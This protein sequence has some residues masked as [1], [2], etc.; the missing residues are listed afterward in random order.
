MT[1]ALNKMSCD[2][3]GNDKILALE[4]N[5]AAVCLEGCAAATDLCSD[6]CYLRSMNILT[7]SG[8]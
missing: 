5:V 4:N 7:T 1:S 2:T 8:S 3:A 6:G